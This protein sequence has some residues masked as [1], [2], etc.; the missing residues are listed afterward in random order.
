MTAQNGLLS[1]DDT[2]SDSGFG[3]DSVGGGDGNDYGSPDA[4]D[5][6]FGGGATTIQAFLEHIKPFCQVPDAFK[7]L[8]GNHELAYETTVDAVRMRFECKV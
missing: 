2:A 3:L 5:G 7:D 1:T 6:G 8:L 4:V